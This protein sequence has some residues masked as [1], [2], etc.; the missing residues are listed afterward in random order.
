ME[1][2]FV[3]FFGVRRQRSC[4][5]EKGSRSGVTECSAE[6]FFVSEVCVS[7]CSGLVALGESWCGRKLAHYVI[8]AAQ[9]TS[10]CNI[11]AGKRI[12]KSR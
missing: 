3:D 8:D 9:L 10:T 1:C 5:V 2:S 11:I 12:A 7:W 4:A 6:P